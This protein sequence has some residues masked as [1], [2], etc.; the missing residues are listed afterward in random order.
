LIDKD[1]IASVT[2][3]L[4]SDFIT[5]GPKVKEFEDALCKYTG[6]KYAVV[7]SN[8]TAALHISCLAAGI[9]TG[10]EVITSPITFAASAN[11]VLYC[12]G[13]PVFAD[14]YEDTTNIDPHEI[15]MRITTKTK[16]LIPVHF[17]G[18][19]YDLEEV[20][21]IAKKNHLVVIEDAAHALGAEYCVQK[22]GRKGEW[23]KVGNS[24]FSDM[25]V[26]SFH[27]V[28]SITTGEG[29][30]VLTN[31]RGLY[32]KLLMYRNH[33]I[34]RESPALFKKNEGP[35]YY[36]MQKLGFNYRITDFQCALGI[37]QLRKID[38]FIRRRREIAKI[39]SDELSKLDGI[40]L[41]VAKPTVRSSWHIYCIRLK[42]PSSRN[43]IFRRLR[44]SNIGVQ[45]HYI[46]VYFHPYYRQLGYGKG[47]CKNAERFYQQT[48]SIPIHPSMTHRDVNYV[49]K[50]LK[51]VLG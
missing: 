37:S 21:D 23:R 18:Q 51:E 41:P 47:V 38:K 3:I 9:K 19:P 49:I 20:S 8:G 4:K 2:E 25:T 39:Y 40:F 36:E 17:T 24:Q 50:K 46:P 33:G 34:T 44:D 26:L 12:G 5:Q 28:K 22:Q 6:A 10:D 7:V 15:E 48:I 14:I 31:D 13:K 42:E 30:A 1:D 27:P 45:V 29:G 32:K 11:C 35:W 43:R 16:A